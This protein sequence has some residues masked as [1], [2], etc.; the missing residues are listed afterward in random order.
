V[1]CPGQPAAGSI[2]TCTL[3]D[4]PKGSG[5][6][7]I[8][9]QAWTATGVESGFSGSGRG[10]VTFEDGSLLV[11]SREPGFDENVK[12][13]RWGLLFT[14]A[15]GPFQGEVFCVGSGSSQDTGTFATKWQLGGFS[16]LPACPP[17]ATGTLTGC[18]R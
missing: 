9:G 18:M 15:E 8:L 13:L 4:C 12:A 16:L 7:S 3:D 2:N 11:V 10:E 5:T 14:A 17:D 1:S 6:G